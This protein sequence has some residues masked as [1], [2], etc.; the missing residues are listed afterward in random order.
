MLQLTPPELSE[1]ESDH[2]LYSLVQRGFIPH[3]TKYIF[4]ELPFTAKTIKPIDP[5]ATPVPPAAVGSSTSSF[6]QLPH[7]MH[8]AERVYKL[9][10][11]YYNGTLK[12]HHHANNNNQQ[13]MIHDANGLRSTMHKAP[14]TF[15][16]SQKSAVLT[17]QRQLAI[18]FH[19]SSHHHHHQQQQQKS[20]GTHHR[21]STGNEV[22]IFF[23]KSVNDI[24]SSSSPTK[25]GRGMPAAAALAIIG[26]NPL[27]STIII[28]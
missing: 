9:D 5:Y 7:A 22:A 1:D 2:G 14:S 25:S 27:V 6:N 24:G 28:N 16:A 12:A 19:P 3:T 21:V 17:D 13:Q 4:D 23:P 26:E 11:A 8:A 18:E 10:P 20:S 15:N